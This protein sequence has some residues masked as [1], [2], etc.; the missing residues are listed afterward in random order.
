MIEKCFERLADRSAERLNVGINEGK[1]S[2]VTLK[3]WVLRS[4]PME[5]SDMIIQAT[6]LKIDGGGTGEGEQRN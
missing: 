5:K 1:H 3:F 6:V 2:K 4:D